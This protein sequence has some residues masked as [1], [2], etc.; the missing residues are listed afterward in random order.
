MFG[1]RGVLASVG[2]GGWLPVLAASV[3]GRAQ[4]LHAPVAVAELPHIKIAARIAANP[5]RAAALSSYP[6]LTAGG[7]TA[8]VWNLSAHVMPVRAVPGDLWLIV[9]WLLGGIYLH[10]TSTWRPPRLPAWLATALAALTLAAA[11]LA[12]LSTGTVLKCLSE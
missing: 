1:L 4:A 7:L 6:W 5:G 10:V 11:V 9:A 2:L 12:A 3:V 8:V